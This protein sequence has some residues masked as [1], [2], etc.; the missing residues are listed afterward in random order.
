[1]RKKNLVALSTILL[2]I[3]MA[4]NSRVCLDS[5]LTDFCSFKPV[6]ILFSLPQDTY[7]SKKWYIEEAVKILIS[8]I[9]LPFEEVT[10]F[11]YLGSTH[12]D[13]KW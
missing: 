10:D 2:L 8:I 4:N 13:R 7:L 6:C 3:N 1:M 9:S 5:V 12:S 11:I